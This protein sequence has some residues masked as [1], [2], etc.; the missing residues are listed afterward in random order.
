MIVVSDASPL[1]YLILIGAENLLQSLFGT[2]F[3]PPAVIAELQNPNTPAKVHA[4]IG[5]YPAWLIVQAP[6]AS[7]SV[8]SA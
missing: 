8:S 2:V 6:D 7:R 3:V 1:N 4:F 5:N